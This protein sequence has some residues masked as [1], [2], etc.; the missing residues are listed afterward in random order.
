MEPDIFKSTPPHTPPPPPSTPPSTP[1]ASLFI[2]QD[3]NYIVN[4]I[5]CLPKSMDFGDTRHL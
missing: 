2:S 5:D 4:V 1:S 3:L